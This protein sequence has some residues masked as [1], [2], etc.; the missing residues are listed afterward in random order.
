MNREIKFRWKKDNWEWVYGYLTELYC[1]WNT[2]IIDYDWNSYQVFSESVWQYTWL[3]D[4]NWNEIYNGDIIE[5]LHN[6][7]F[8][9]IWN[10]YYSEQYWRYKVRINNEI[11]FELWGYFDREVKWNIY[12]NP[13]LLSD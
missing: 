11:T 9:R 12:E 4:K 10:V 1:S 2:E 13:E 5:R 6:W 3:K 8:I 7:E